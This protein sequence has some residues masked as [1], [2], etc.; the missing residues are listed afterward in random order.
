M[1]TRPRAADG[2]TQSV[3]AHGRSSRLGGGII[4]FPGSAGGNGGGSCGNTPA[5]RTRGEKGDGTCK[6]MMQP[7]AGKEEVASQRRRRPCPSGSAPHAVGA[8]A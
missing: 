6:L 8:C 7:A 3:P 1:H 5:G 2:S 4:I